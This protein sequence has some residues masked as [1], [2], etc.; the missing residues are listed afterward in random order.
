MSG[1]RW[2]FVGA[3]AALLGWLALLAIP[4]VPGTSG[5][6]IDGGPWQAPFDEIST[7]V[8]DTVRGV[9][10]VVVLRRGQLVLAEGNVTEPLNV[11]AARHAILALLY[12]IAVER[13]LIA[14]DLNLTRIGI[15]ESAAPLSPPQKAATLED[16][17]RSRSG[18][19]LPFVE[20]PEGAGSRQSGTTPG[21]TFRLSP[22]DVDI[23]AV[24]FERETGIGIGDAIA[25][26][27]AAPLGLQD[28]QA[29]HVY[30]D[31]DTRGS[32]YPSFQIYLS[33]RDLAQIGELIRRNGRI[34][35]RQIVPSTWIRR[36]LAPWSVAESPAP[37]MPFDR[38]GYGWWI[39]QSRQLVGA[40][41][42]DAAY[43]LVDQE[44][45]GLVIV[46][47]RDGGRSVLAQW[48]R[49]R[50]G[51]RIKADDVVKIWSMSGGRAL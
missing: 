45:P 41:G 16:L 11:G 19:V 51:P 42:K 15:E 47:A 43:L 37:E 28:F 21:L 40:V 39:A 8:A 23:L 3:G 26:W 27:L 7:Y 46:A 18:I 2:L 1:L 33:P 10:A 4:V 31:T 48:W 24:A 44:R 14:M 5:P 50:F 49:R 32:D 12:G 38:Y 22:W 13:G 9:D 36:M 30:F 34:Q 25:E 29:P 20:L 17:M 6:P 35:A